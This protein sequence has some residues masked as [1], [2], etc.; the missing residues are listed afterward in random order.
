VKVR[1]GDRNDDQADGGRAVT[2]FRSKID[3][4]LAALLV[5]AAIIQIVVAIWIVRLGIPGCWAIAA[6]LMAVVGLI[7]W[8][9]FQT[10]YRLGDDMLRI[11]CG[12]FSIQIPLASITAVTATRNPLSS[13]ALSLDRLMITY[14]RG[15]S[16]MISPHD[17]A[18]FLAELARRGITT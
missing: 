1:G 5:G 18:A 2:N 14:G 16:C 8:M 6:I 12:P 4:W 15:Q 7:L 3:G 9:L 13:P 10:V 11:R 17:K